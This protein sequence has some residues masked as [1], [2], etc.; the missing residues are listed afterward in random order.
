MSYM[1]VV[2]L[3]GG[4]GTRFAE[5]TANVPKPM[6]K[7]GEQP[8]LWHIM[9]LYAAH[10]FEDFV[11]ALGYKAEVVKNYF[12]NYHALAGDLSI[13]LATGRV[14]SIRR[15]E[16]HWRVHLVDTG[17]DTMTG[18]RIKRLESLLRRETFLLTYGDGVTNV[19]LRKVVDFH[20][21][22]GKVATITAVRPPARFGN[23]GFD[24]DNV[25]HFAEKRQTD[26]GW[27]NGGF[28][29]LD[30]KVFDY[31]KGDADVLEVDL[32]ERLAHERQLVAY[33]HDGFWQCMD[34]LRDQQLLQR[35]WM[36][37]DCPWKT[38]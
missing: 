23:I 21:R 36:S 31:L 17:I 22:C 33:K 7:I 3:A 5:E 28:M 26:E 12:L 14:E 4:L 1:K 30:P 10:G 18:G 6:I 19:D 34:T 20:R 9:K 15:H 2:I 27:V 35:L 11:V 38:W 13:D 8:I 25:A 29:V 37:G 16:E 32:L 24:G